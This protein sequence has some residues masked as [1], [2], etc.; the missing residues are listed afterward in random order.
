MLQ[1]LNENFIGI[2]ARFFEEPRLIDETSIA[3]KVQKVRKPSA[4][5]VHFQPVHLIF[6]VEFYSR[7][8]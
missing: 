6:F 7:I 4:F 5:F 3:E 2:K 1:N 8:S